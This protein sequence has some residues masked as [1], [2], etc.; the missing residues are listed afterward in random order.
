MTTPLVNASKHE[1]VMVLELRNPP[2]NTYSYEMMRELDSH[3]LEAR[4]DSTV[5]VLLIIG[6]GDKFFCA[7]ADIERLE[8][9]NPYFKYDG[10]L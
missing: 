4:F 6:A 2:A 3:V 5:H 7:G 1:G 9:A 8:K 10:V